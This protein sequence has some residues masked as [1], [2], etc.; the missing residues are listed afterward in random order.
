MLHVDR[1]LDRRNAASPGAAPV[2][3]R[4]A[5]DSRVVQS[6]I[7]MLRAAG[8]RCTL[9]WRDDRV[10]PLSAAEALDCTVNHEVSA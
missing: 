9:I 10:Q 8:C 2:P 6:A 1:E 3:D 5:P 7:D 4:R